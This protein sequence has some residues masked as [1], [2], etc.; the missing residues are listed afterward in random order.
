MR[1]GGGRD[2]V[3]GMKMALLQIDPTVG[4]LDGNA[5]LLAEA[6]GVARAA[7]ADLAVASELSLLGYPPRDLL[8]RRSFVAR[9]WQVC[10]E[11]AD[12]LSAGPPLLLGL[13]ETNP[14]AAGRPL[15]NAAALLA[16]GTVRRVFRKTLLPTYDVFDEDRYFEPAGGPQVLSWGEE[17]IGVSV[18][19]DVWNDRDF[20]SRQRYHI[21][22]I[23]DLA[24]AGVSC[25]VNMSASPF[26]IGKQRH[27]EAMLAAIARK[28][29]VPVIYVNQAGGADELVFD[30]RSCA[31]AAG[32]ELMARA[33]A[34]APD[35][36][37]V[38]LEQLA[39]RS[40]PGAG[41]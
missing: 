21:D 12:R 39:G 4:D 1:H 34:F 3:V 19:E 29:G 36:L 41:P 22:P 11:L 16:G 40:G 32:G 13:A 31:F 2:S 5:A 20:W 27:R 24:T 6:A 30:G 28:Y 37:V 26:T 15:Y 7:G 33:A 14:G 38:D 23:D 18:C 10:E 17:R 9:G 35:V 25:V 8:L